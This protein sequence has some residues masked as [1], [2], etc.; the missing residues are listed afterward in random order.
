MPSEIALRQVGFAAAVRDPRKESVLAHDNN[1]RA[2]EIFQDDVAHRLPGM[3]G[4]DDQMELDEVDM[5]HLAATACP[6]LKSR[7]MHGDPALVGQEH[8]T[9]LLQE[10]VSQLTDFLAAEARRSVVREFLLRHRQQV[11]RSHTLLIAV[12]DRYRITGVDIA[13]LSKVVSS[14]ESTTHVAGIRTDAA[15]SKREKTD[16]ANI[17]RGLLQTPDLLHKA[18]PAAY[19]D[20]IKQ[21]RAGGY[22]HSRADGG[23]K[24]VE[25]NLQAAQYSEGD[26][27]NKAGAA[28]TWDGTVYKQ[29]LLASLRRKLGY[30]LYFDALHHY[31][32]AMRGARVTVLSIQARRLSKVHKLCFQALVAEALCARHTKSRAEMIARRLVQAKYMRPTI[33]CVQRWKKMTLERAALWGRAGRGFRHAQYRHMLRRLEHGVRTQIF[34]AHSIQLVD[35]TLR[36]H[37]R[38]SVVNTLKRQMLWQRHMGRLERHLQAHLEEWEAAAPLRGLR[39][40]CKEIRRAKRNARLA[41]DHQLTR[42]HHRVIQA[43]QHCAERRWHRSRAHVLD[44]LVDKQ[45]LRP[46]CNWTVYA[47]FRRRVRRSNARA[48][49]LLSRTRGRQG[50]DSWRWHAK[51]ALAGLRRMRMADALC[52]AH[53]VSTGTN[54]LYVSAMRARS[55]RLATHRGQAFFKF[56]KWALS[57]ETM[58]DRVALGRRAAVMWVL[59]GDSWRAHS[60]LTGMAAFKE[61]WS[62][63][64]RARAL[65]RWARER[66]LR[67]CMAHAHS[68]WTLAFLRKSALRL[69]LERRVTR[70]QKMRA[71]G[72]EPP[73]RS[74]NEDAQK[75]ES[76]M[77]ALKT[78]ALARIGAAANVDAPLLRRYLHKIRSS[79]AASSKVKHDLRIKS[80]LI[81]ADDFG[82]VPAAVKQET[83]RGEVVA[84]HTVHK[85]EHKPQHTK[86]TRKTVHSQLPAPVPIVAR[87][88]VRTAMPPLTPIMLARASVGSNNDSESTA[89]SSGSDS[90]A[91]REDG[92]DSSIASANHSWGVASFT[93]NGQESSRESM[94]GPSFTALMVEAN[95]RSESSLQRFFKTAHSAIR[96][97]DPPLQSD[98]LTN[99]QLKPTHTLLKG[100]RP[101]QPV[102]KGRISSFSNM[103]AS[104]LTRSRSPVREHEVTPSLSPSRIRTHNSPS[105]GSDRFVEEQHT[106]HS[107]IS[108]VLSVSAVDMS[109]GGGLLERSMEISSTG[110]FKM[111]SH[112]FGEAAVREQDAADVTES[113]GS[114]SEDEFGRQ[115]RKVKSGAMAGSLDAAL[116]LVRAGRW[117][118]LKLR[119]HARLQMA[120]RATRKATRNRRLRIAKFGW[121][122]VHL[123][124]C[125]TLEMCHKMWVV[126]AT[127]AAVKQLFLRGVTRMRALRAQTVSNA[128]FL[129]VAVVMREWRKQFFLFKSERLAR[130]GMQ[131]AQLSSHLVRWRWAKK[132]VPSILK[133]KK[134]QAR[135]ILYPCI[136]LWHSKARKLSKLR[137][138]FHQFFAAWNHRWGLINNRT[139]KSRLYECYD[140]W[141]AFLVIVKE[142]RYVQQQLHKATVFGS[143]VLKARC[144]MGWLDFHLMC[145]KVKRNLA[146]RARAK[147]V[148][149][150]LV[151]RVFLR[152]MYDEY[153]H[154]KAQG[155]RGIQHRNTRINRTCFSDWAIQARAHFHALPERVY[156]HHLMRTAWNV[157]RLSRRVRLMYGNLLPSQRMRRAR[158]CLYAWHRI[159][160]RK[161][162]MVEGGKKLEAALMKMR[163]RAVMQNWPGRESFEKAEEMR[164]KLERQGRAKI[165]LVDVQ[166]VEDARLKRALAA[167]A[168]ADREQSFIQMRKAAAIEKR[169]ALFGFIS[170]P[171]DHEAV[172]DLFDMLRA[173]LYGWAD[174][175]H[176]DASLRG[177]ERLV[178]FRHKRALLLH[179]LRIWIGRCSA[180]SHRLALWISQKYGKAEHRKLQMDKNSLATEHLVAQYSKL[181]LEKFLDI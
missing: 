78:E 97:R 84:R 47:V 54:A 58:G 178:K 85:G 130:R 80:R 110:G 156:T 112:I 46:L 2:F 163:V 34:K 168:E 19:H 83:R 5:Q 121:V 120:D 62:I 25:P 60:L 32:V 128:Y 179:G 180:T 137:R 141:R 42:R 75:L 22:R 4:E 129:R 93:V 166:K 161:V 12:Q 119:R 153:A 123:K 31:A 56:N 113:E 35:A 52:W 115:S 160:T 177:M 82:V 66:A 14:Q 175:A 21:I 122:Q 26:I 53:G 68:A 3:D 173:V 133:F 149:L 67:S 144:F 7:T 50:V 157:L 146:N 37:A 1:Y 41:T 38:N 17:V 134:K 132:Y 148:R 117:A 151:Q 57:F 43:L 36:A 174:I 49:L 99:V 70:D 90:D 65:R 165:V 33:R 64:K 142:E 105:R 72:Q 9:R 63:R 48:I 172:S 106:P 74:S 69:A 28:S 11:F 101:A 24:Q 111:H 108:N 170:S 131:L 20:R 8:Y 95:A 167:K 79:A 44:L 100:S 30:K 61:Q 71:M 109:V 154:R 40:A 145:L 6:R 81:N 104:Q 158:R 125:K 45:Q 88:P 116:L 140:G 164:V 76:D 98:Y 73:T 10:D 139:D 147:V 103:R 51:S 55:A 13:A 171:D 152:A 89:G 87:A 39:M 155:Q 114:D 176:V 150:H 135:R 77:M 138:V 126:K 169:A 107:S 23:L 162:N 15:A 92:R 118:L 27:Y 124:F 59:G 29:T 127:R 96:A 181:G 159:F 18:T 94:L 86:A 136:N 16:T 143:A 102:E 91:Y